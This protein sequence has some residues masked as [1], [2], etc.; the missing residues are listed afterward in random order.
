MTNET[1]PIWN[2]PLIDSLPITDSGMTQAMPSRADLRMCR[3]RNE[4]V[5]AGY[6]VLLAHY[7]RVCEERDRLRG[8]LREI[9]EWDRDY[10]SLP[11]G[12]VERIEKENLP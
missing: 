3:G 1:G 9:N 11:L 8:L 7:H 6:E 10:P 4:R 12:I 5:A 2:V